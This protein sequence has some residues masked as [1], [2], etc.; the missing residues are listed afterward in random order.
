M[1]PHAEERNELSRRLG[2]GG[3]NRIGVEREEFSPQ[4]DA[5]PLQSR[6]D[7]QKRL[8]VVT[9]PDGKIERFRDNP[10]RYL[11]VEREK[12]TGRIVPVAFDGRPQYLMLCREEIENV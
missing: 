7:E 3:R 10:V 11:V 9:M 5:D 4:I 8:F 2:K 6:H 12:R 1:G